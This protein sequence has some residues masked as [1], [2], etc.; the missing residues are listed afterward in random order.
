ME[1]TA[2]S[3]LN[4]VYSG[5]NNALIVIRKGSLAMK[6]FVALMLLLV[7]CGPAWAARKADHVFIIS[8]DGGKPSVMQESKMPTLMSLV[9]NGAAT[10]DAQTIFPSI[11]LTSHT[12][13]LT[14]LTPEKHNVYWNEW[15]P[16]RGIITSPTIFKLAK[17]HKL[18]TAMFVGKP[19]FI[20]LYQEK[21][22]NQFSLPSHLAVDAATA[23]AQYIKIKKPNLCFIH[24][25]DSDSAGHTFGWGST[26]QKESFKTEDH[27]LEIVMKAIEEAGIKDRSVVIMSADHGGHDKTHG[28]RS[29]E[30]MTIPWIVS[31]CGVKSGFKIEEGVTTYDTA[32]TALWLLDVPMPPNFDGKPVSNAFSFTKE[33]TLQTPPA[34]N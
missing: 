29:A 7:L 23:A 19:K 34:V 22:L 12:S 1:P 6:F 2:E 17:A 9:H 20:H 16:Q 30:D 13:M 4:A 15:E 26:Q 18:S 31:G 5:E 14:G 33:V 32:A 8:F 24:F 11:T 25:T 21:S 28:T 3:A 10:W 27:A